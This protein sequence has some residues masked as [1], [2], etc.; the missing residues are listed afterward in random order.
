MARGED[1]ESAALEQSRHSH[2]IALTDELDA[3]GDPV[4]GSECL[5]LCPFLTVAGDDQIWS[6]WMSVQDETISVDQ[7]VEALG[8]HVTTSSQQVGATP[9]LRL[10]GSKLLER[11]RRHG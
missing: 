3:V 4:R 9:M 6:L 11:P 1:E 2:P 10:G 8:V 7:D 5:E